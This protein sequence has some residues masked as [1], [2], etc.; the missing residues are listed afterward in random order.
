[1]KNLT[2]VLIVVTLAAAWTSP[3]SAQDAQAEKT[4]IAA[5]RAIAAAYAKGDSAG[6]KEHVSVDG[7]NIGAAFGRGPVTDFFK[8]FDAITKGIKISSWDLSDSKINWV[9][10]NTAVHSYKMTVKG[11]AEGQ[12]MP[13][14]AW[15]STVWTKKN[16]K[17]MAAFHQETVPM[18]GAATA[19]K[20]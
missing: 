8:D 7:W 19:P 14:T 2:R 18:P 12:P 5:E 4:I 9:D 15:N 10:A 17:W 3:A 20:K 16:G 11:T 1:M 13:E 6:M